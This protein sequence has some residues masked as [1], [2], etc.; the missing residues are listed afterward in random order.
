[1]GRT[2][3]S[4][5]AALCGSGLLACSGG[6]GEAGAHGADA[7]STGD[8]PAAFTRPQL[9]GGEGDAASPAPDASVADASPPD[10]S[11]PDASPPDASTWPDGGPF[12]ANCGQDD[13][14]DSNR[15]ADFHCTIG[16]EPDDPHA[17]R[18]VVGLC[19]L[20]RNVRHACIGDVASGSDADDLL[21]RPAQP[22][23]AMAASAT[24]AT[25][26]DLD[27]ARIAVP[28]GHW[29]VVAT[30]AADV[31]LALD[32]YDARA[33]L[34]G[35]SDDGV[36]SA[37]ESASWTA[38]DDLGAFVVLRHVGG[39]TGAYTLRLESVQP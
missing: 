3:L 22:P 33:H 13:E 21:L 17:C 37:S 8:A 30:P 16:C 15:C 32:F 27:V 26:G 38:S 14:C 2:M 5:A 10:A 9:D 34:I 35:T 24:F 25:P 39:A 11:P 18:N 19:A 29:R 28:P 36:A 12:G 6:G 4:V 31:D 20:V 23:S 1:M 7:T